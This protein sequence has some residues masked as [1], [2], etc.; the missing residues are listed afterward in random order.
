MNLS[1]I[2]GLSNPGQ[3]SPGIDRSRQIQDVLSAR[4]WCN[5][6]LYFENITVWHIDKNQ[7]RTVFGMTK[8]SSC[9]VSDW[10]FNLPKP[11]CLNKPRQFRN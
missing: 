10:T 5:G 6:T 9:I 8:Q 4:T 7:L 11:I 2:R 3:G 1:H